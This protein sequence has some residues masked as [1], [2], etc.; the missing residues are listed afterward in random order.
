MGRN[1]V[2]NANY[3]D[4]L[5]SRLSP[6]GLNVLAIHAEVEGIICRDM[7]A[8]FLREATEKGWSFEPLGGFVDRTADLPECAIT[9]GAVPGREGWVACQAASRPS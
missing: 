3:N 1:G 8:R 6:S 2:T 7:F 5:L 9:A 4:F